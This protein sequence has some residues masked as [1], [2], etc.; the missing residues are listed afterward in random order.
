V[1][2]TSASAW[3]PNNQKNGRAGIRC[4][5]ATAKQ[6]YESRFQVAVAVVRLA[7]YPLAL[8]VLQS[9][10]LCAWQSITAKERSQGLL[11]T[12][13]IPSEA[14]PHLQI[15][16]SQKMH[17]LG[18]K[19]LNNCQ[20]QQWMV[21]HGVQ[22]FDEKPLFGTRSHKTADNANASVCTCTRV[23]SFSSRQIYTPRG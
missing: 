9:T 8:A 16:T 1:H 4:K 19:M 7:M 21:H 17:I 14:D 22:Q 3:K 20:K 23:R 15:Y 10:C 12:I 2:A 18:I 11:A 13:C 5:L 6:C